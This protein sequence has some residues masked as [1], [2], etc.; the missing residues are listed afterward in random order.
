M[1]QGADVSVLVPVLDEAGAIRATV[2][3]MQAQ[4]FGG[5]LE[6]IF[7][8]GGSQDAT[9]EILG[10]LAQADP[11]IR[12]LENPARRVPQA[13]NLGLAHSTGRYVVRMDAHTR[14]PPDY[15]ALGVRRLEAGD[16][17]WVSGP[18]LAVGEGPWSRR[19]AMAL[20][21]RL[22]VGGASFRLSTDR[23]IEVD[24]GFTGVWRRTT[25]EAHGGWDEGWPVNQDAEL[26]ARVRASG[27]RIVCLPEMAASYSPRES[28]AA[29]ARQYYSY[30]MYRAKTSR[31]HSESMR[32]SQ[33]LPPALVLALAGSALPGRPGRAPRALLGVY[34]VAVAA[35][36]AAQAKPGRRGD[37]ALLPAVFATMHVAWGAGFIAGSRRFGPP[38]AALAAMVRPPRARPPGPSGGG[39]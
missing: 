16:V 34:A 4:R 39:G 25:L 22:G 8:D 32:R 2:A 14:Y 38:V 11:R 27:G 17:E 12:V 37:A 35:A 36:S 33:I 9:R 3:A 19:I 18:Q 15:I 31:R 30:G 26:A 20:Q 24:T 7:L 10:E 21:S 1:G 6:F 28:L 29:L 23:E 13:L 5:Q